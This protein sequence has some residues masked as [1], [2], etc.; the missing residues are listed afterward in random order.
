[1]NGE[2]WGWVGGLIQTNVDSKM[3]GDRE[4]WCEGF[5]PFDCLTFEVGEQLAECSVSDQIQVASVDS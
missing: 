3:L 1:M 2:S 5:C 4:G